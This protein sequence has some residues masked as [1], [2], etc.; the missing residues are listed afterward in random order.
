MSYIFGPDPS[1]G[2]CCDT[3]VGG[4]SCD[5]PEFI[6]DPTM[7][8]V[9]IDKDTNC[10]VAMEAPDGSIPVAGPTGV[11]HRTGAS[12]DAITLPY[13]E[14]HDPDNIAY[15]LVQT[16][17]GQIKKWRPTGAIDGQDEYLVFDGTQWRL[18]D[19]E[20]DVCFDPANVCETCSPTHVAA[21][22]EDP[23]TG[24]LCL[25][26]ADLANIDF[27]DI[28]CNPCSVDGVGSV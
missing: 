10:P 24:R 17:T 2:R 14:P 11:E 1:L 15:L 26:K 22:Y 27:G 20:R 6:T 21:L 28:D 5:V 23:T 4:E 13:L 8:L 9:G 7:G 18:V 3:E 25:Q 19:G 12:G 16:T